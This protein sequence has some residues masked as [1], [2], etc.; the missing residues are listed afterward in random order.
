MKVEQGWGARERKW[1]RFYPGKEKKGE[2]QKEMALGTWEGQS[3][4]EEMEGER[5]NEGITQRLMERDGERGKEGYEWEPG[6]LP[7]DM[8]DME[9]GAESIWKGMTK[10][11]AG[12]G[13]I[14]QECIRNDPIS[15]IYARYDAMEQGGEEGGDV[16]GI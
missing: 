5:V 8:I 11:N 13:M 16:A 4:K 1:S 3:I 6:T 15:A 9:E 12:Y 14:S 10:R 2:E 7:L